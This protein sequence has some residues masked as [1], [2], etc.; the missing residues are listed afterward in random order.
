[1]HPHALDVSTKHCSFFIFRSI[2]LCNFKIA[3]IGGL[4]TGDTP[5]RSARIS[6]KVKSPEAEKPKRASDS[7]SQKGTKRKKNT[8]DDEYK[9]KGDGSGSRKRSKRKK[10]TENDEHKAEVEVCAAE[11]EG[12]KDV[13]MEE[14]KG[15]EHNNSNEEASEEGIKTKESVEENL[16][17]PVESQAAIKHDLT[18]KAMENEDEKVEQDVEKSEGKVTKLEPGNEAKENQNGTETSPPASDSEKVVLTVKADEVSDSKKD[19]ASVRKKD[20]EILSENGSEM[21]IKVSP[22]V[23]DSKKV[24]LIEKDADVSTAEKDDFSIHLKDAE[25][26]P[27]NDGENEEVKAAPDDNLE[28]GKEVNE[29]LNVTEVSPPSFDSEKVV[30]TAKDD[31]ASAAAKKDEAS[32]FIK[33]SEILSENGEK[34]D[35]V[36]G[37]LVHNCDDGKMFES[38]PATR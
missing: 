30:L 24:T 7:G 6:E 1:M 34:K 26:M 3:C 10:N 29:N 35:E 2:R 32:V 22:A 36:E 18:D 11:G 31:E 9:V 19:E 23:P 33:G 16:K 27:E 15:N 12:P 17:G 5:R 38:F 8:E 37:N 25:N 21:D 14:T 13:D 4:L 28:P 20:V